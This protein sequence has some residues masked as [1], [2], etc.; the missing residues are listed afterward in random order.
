[1][2]KIA[3]LIA[4]L[5]LGFTCTSCDEPPVEEI[6]YVEMTVTTENQTLVIDKIY[7]CESTGVITSQ[8]E[9][10]GIYK[11]PQNGFINIYWHS[12]YGDNNYKIKIDVGTDTNVNIILKGA[13]TVA[14]T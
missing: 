3:Y 5:A 10:P 6:K 4:F 14:F 1:M 13:G 9:N 2:K 12:V 8:G 11:V 7:C